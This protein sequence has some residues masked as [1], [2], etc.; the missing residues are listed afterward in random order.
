MNEKKIEACCLSA[1]I[2]NVFG[3]L[4]E[5]CYIK[6]NG[7]RTSVSR[8]MKR[9][10]FHGEIAHHWHLKGLKRGQVKILIHL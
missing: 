5:E 8:S 6:H 3:H 10:N 9:S 2:F 1:R 4:L 7:L